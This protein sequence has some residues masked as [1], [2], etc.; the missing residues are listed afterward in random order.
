MSDPFSYN[1]G[2]MVGMIGKKCV[3]IGCDRRQGQQF[4]TINTN[5]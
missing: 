3:A 1:G 5:F 4:Q 2:A